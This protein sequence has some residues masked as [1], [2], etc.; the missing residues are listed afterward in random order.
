[1]RER[2]RVKGDC[3]TCGD[4]NSAS[5]RTCDVIRVLVQPRRALEDQGTKRLIDAYEVTHADAIRT[6]QGMNFELTSHAT[7][8]PVGDQVDRSD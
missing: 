8:I 4:T 2:A 1:M 7:T 6:T 3:R 5:R